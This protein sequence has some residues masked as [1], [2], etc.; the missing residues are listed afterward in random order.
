MKGSLRIFDTSTLAGLKAAEQY[1]A[2]LENAYDRVIVN[3]AGLNRVQIR[4][5]EKSSSDETKIKWI[6]VS[7]D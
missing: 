5:E 4:A 1:K 2:A 7:E 3:S 6:G